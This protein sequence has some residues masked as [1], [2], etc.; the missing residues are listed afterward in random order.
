MWTAL[1]DDK[2]FLSF[3]ETSSREHCSWQYENDQLGITVIISPLWRAPIG[4]F[5]PIIPTQNFVQSRKPN[6]YFL[7]LH[8]PRI[9][10]NP[11]SRVSNKENPESR[12]SN[13]KNPEPRVSVWSKEN[14][15]YRVSN[16]GNPES[17]ETHW[18]P[19]PFEDRKKG[20]SSKIQKRFIYFLRQ[21]TPDY[22]FR[23]VCNYASESY[24]RI[25]SGYG[26]SS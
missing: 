5:S 26:R 6:G 22:R 1:D 14:P 23:A 18:D 16:K 21:F 24:N 17:R 3:S 25:D 7:A 4:F 8:L 15:E 9:L 12:A 11:E 20:F 2:G 10:S 13:K 19:P